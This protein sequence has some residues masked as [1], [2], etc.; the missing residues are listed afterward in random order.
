MK[1]NIFVPG[2]QS[3]LKTTLLCLLINFITV[4]FG[5]HKGTDL[6]A[7]GTCL[8][9][10][11]VPLYAYIFGDTVRPSNKTEEQKIAA[12]QSHA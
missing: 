2:K 9:L 6:T 5:I 8:A 12:A 7:L 4:W 11:N 1:L 10:I 3:R